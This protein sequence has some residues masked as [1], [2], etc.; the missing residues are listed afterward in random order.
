MRSSHFGGIKDIVVHGINPTLY[1]FSGFVL[2]YFWNFF[3][4]VKSVELW[5]SFY[6]SLFVSGVS[7]IECPKISKMYRFSIYANRRLKSVFKIWI[8][9]LMNPRARLV[10]SLLPSSCQPQVI[11][12]V[13]QWIAVYMVNGHIFR[14]FQNFSVKKH[15]A[16]IGVSRR[17]CSNL[18]HI[19]VTASTILRPPHNMAKLFVVRVVNAGKNIFSIGFSKI[20]PLHVSWSMQSCLHCQ[21]AKI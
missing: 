1:C 20:Y 13:V 19:A 3:R 16:L 21:G 4:F 18:L 17:F 8:F 12:S 2:F 7:F 10:L 9:H 15:R 11:P 14:T 5:I 6:A